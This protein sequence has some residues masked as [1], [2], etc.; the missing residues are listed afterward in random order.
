MIP[1]RESLWVIKAGH[2]A[3]LY[4]TVVKADEKV[5]QYR[6]GKGRYVHAVQTDFFVR[7]FE[8]FDVEKHG[9]GKP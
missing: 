2:G 9:G 1:S 8:P 4:A 6:I 5:T 3:G 7:K